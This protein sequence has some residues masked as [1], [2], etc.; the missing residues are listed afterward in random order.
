MS[1]HWFAGTA[2]SVALGCAPLGPASLEGL[3]APYPSVA[4]A[5]AAADSAGTS[6]L[7]VVDTVVYNTSNILPRDREV[8]RVRLVRASP[9]G[10]GSGPCYSV[11]FIETRRPQWTPP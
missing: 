6:V 1:R 7:F 9:R 8:A 4:A 10:C 3:G 5:R 2:A 11:V